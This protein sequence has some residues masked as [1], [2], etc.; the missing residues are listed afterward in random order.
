[1][2]SAKTDI[3]IFSDFKEQLNKLG[4]NVDF[5]ILTATNFNVLQNRRRL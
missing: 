4:Y 2:L 1:M 5:K 3:E